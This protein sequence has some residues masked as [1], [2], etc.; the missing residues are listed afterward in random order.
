MIVVYKHM[1]YICM[2]KERDRENERNVLNILVYIYIYTI[3]V[4][5]ARN[6]GITGG[7]NDAVGVEDIT[8]GMNE[9]IGVPASTG[10]VKDATLKLPGR[11]GG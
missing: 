1:S 3:Y 11:A 2:K 6:R 7:A 9:L 4:T 5:I 10:G 8:G